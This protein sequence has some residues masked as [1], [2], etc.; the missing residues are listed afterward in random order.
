MTTSAGGDMLSCLA[1]V[2]VAG[3]HFSCLYKK[4]AI[5]TLTQCRGEYPHHSVYTSSYITNSAYVLQGPHT[6]NY[7]IPEYDIIETASY[8]ASGGQT[9]AHE[10]KEGLRS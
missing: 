9:R 3:S 2:C 6:S 7:Y 4:Q 10:T 5:K 1:A 8:Y